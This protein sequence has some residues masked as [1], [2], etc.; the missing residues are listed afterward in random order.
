MSKGRDAEALHALA[1]LRQLP[2]TDTR[3]QQ[4][5]F[6]IRAEVAFHRETSALR[7][8]ELQD[9]RLISR[10]KLEIVSW[11]DC[12]K[13]GCW[14]RTHT[15]VGLMFFQQFVG[16]NALIYYS[17]TLFKTMGLNYSLQLIMSGVLNVTQLVGV[18]TSL[19]TMDRFGRRPLLL[20]GSFFMTLSHL[21]IAILVGKFSNDWPGHRAA[22]W[23]SVAFLLFYMLSFGASWG[24]VRIF[25]SNFC[26]LVI[27][28]NQD[29][30]GR[31]VRRSAPK[32]LD[33]KTISDSPPSTKLCLSSESR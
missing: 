8:P 33:A 11:T 5:W 1:K 6:D 2:T 12:F 30:A 15:G 27:Y 16:I 3:I 7:H 9:Q 14:R 24:P 17:P 25:C 21:I 10:V 29:V 26:F 20:W 19:W 32:V 23:V 18:T 13:R 4:E 31:D 22:G 28:G